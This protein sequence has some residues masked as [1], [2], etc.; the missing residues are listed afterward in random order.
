MP[1]IEYKKLPYF[2]KSIDED[3]RTVTGIFA[4]HGNRDEGGDI[5]ENGSFAKYLKE[6][7]S[8]VRFLWSHDGW[9]PP[10]ASIK[11]IRE[12]GR[13][14]LPPKVLE[15]AEDA[16]GG[17]EVTRQY[18][19]DVEM[20][21]WVFK[22]IQAG[23]LEEMSYAYEIH[24]YEI[25]I[26]EETE[27]R[28]RILKEVELFDISDVNWGMNPATAGVK[29]IPGTGMTFTQHSEQVVST[30][31]AY[32][33]RVKDRKSFREEEERTLSEPARERLIKIAAE[34]RAIIEETEPKADPAEVQQVLSDYLRIEQGLA[35]VLSAN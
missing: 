26:D 33:A 31:E 4:V 29:G 2:I 5:S 22:A 17:L 35:G 25:E 18:Y 8:R 6:G 7:R 12:V 19:K 1:N 15:W 10:I 23:D 3:S 9:Q 16:T 30:L 27:I 14:E 34:I 28:T 20:S 32:V 13:D 24:K 21:E 11:E